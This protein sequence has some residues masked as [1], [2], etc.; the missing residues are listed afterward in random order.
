MFHEPR[1]EVVVAFAVLDAVGPG[2]IAGGELEFEVG[3]GVVGED[4]FDDL[5][6]GLVLEDLAV[7]GSGKQPSPGANNDE[8]LVMAVVL[9]YPG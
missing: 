6:E 9:P 2:L 3:V 1:D 5:A 8:I 4:G 7:A